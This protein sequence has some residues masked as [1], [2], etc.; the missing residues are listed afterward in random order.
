[1]CGVGVDCMRA[2][3]AG[4][5]A[6]QAGRKEREGGGDG[7][8]RRC[9]GCWGRTVIHRRLLRSRGGLGLGG[10]RGEEERMPVREC[11]R[12]RPLTFK[13]APRAQTRP[14]SGGRPARAAHTV[15]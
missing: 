8:G 4:V 10:L 15:H 2:Y 5:P 14:H 9:G 13:D 11:Q 1:M 3:G 6:G 12:P 7:S